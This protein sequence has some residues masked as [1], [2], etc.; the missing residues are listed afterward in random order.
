MFNADYIHISI[1]PDN[2][3]FYLLFYNILNYVTKQTFFN[4]TNL[5]HVLFGKQK[6]LKKNTSYVYY[7]AIFIVLQYFI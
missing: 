1:S 7:Y 2:M 4:A 3:M 5:G 6:L